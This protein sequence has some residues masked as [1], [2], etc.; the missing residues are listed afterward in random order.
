[1]IVHVHVYV[2]RNLPGKRPLQKLE[3]A[4]PMYIYISMYM[5]MCILIHVYV[6]AFCGGTGVLARNINLNRF[7]GPYPLLLAPP[8][9]A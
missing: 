4:F 5:N 3:Y 9:K 1:M 8:V 2:Y 6:V 7:Y